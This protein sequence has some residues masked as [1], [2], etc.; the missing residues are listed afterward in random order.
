MLTSQQGSVYRIILACVIALA[1][2]FALTWPK[3]SKHRNVVH[4]RQAAHTGKALAFAEESY[5]QIHGQYTA[6]FEQLQTALPCPMVMQEQAPVM[7]CPH[8]TYK[9]QAGNIIHVKNTHFPVWLDIDIQQGTVQCNY[10][11]DDW[12]G[13]DLCEHLQ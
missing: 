10:A 1:F 6:H 5:K 11:D 2:C 8:Y 9:L 12:A 7:Q 13:Q 4:L 3:Y